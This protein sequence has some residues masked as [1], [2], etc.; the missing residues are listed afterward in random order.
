[1]PEPPSYVVKLFP[2]KE[3]YSVEDVIEY[4]SVYQQTKGQTSIKLWE[5]AIELRFQVG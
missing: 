2:E 3:A 5:E 1:M 4:C